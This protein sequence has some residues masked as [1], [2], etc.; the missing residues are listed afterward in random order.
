MSEAQTADRVTE[1]WL[2]TLEA[3]GYLNITRRYMYDL[4]NAGLIAFERL[5][6]PNGDPG[7]YRFKAAD[8][9]AYM[10]RSQAAGTS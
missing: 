7:E 9:D 6:K 4:V 2:N 1:K 5:T 8:L 3:C 10:K